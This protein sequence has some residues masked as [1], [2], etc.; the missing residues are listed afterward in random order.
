MSLCAFVAHVNKI[1]DWLEQLLHRDNRPPQVK[2]VDN[3]LM[4]ILKTEYLSP[5]KE[6]C[7][8]SVSTA[9]PKDRPSL[10][11]FVKALSC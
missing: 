6:K 9:Q 7:V 4:D 2:L 3:E 11:G 5:G 8:G 10:S 1:N